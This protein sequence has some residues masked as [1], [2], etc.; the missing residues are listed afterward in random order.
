MSF[1]NASETALLNLLFN[2]SAWANVGDASG[3]QPSATAGSYFI[4]LHSSDPGEAGNQ[5]TNEISYTGYARVAVARSG[6]GWTVSGNSVQNA[7]LVQFGQCTSGTAT[8]THFA[9]GTA[10]SS[11][12]SVLMKGALSASLSI[13]NGIQP[14]FA[15]GALVASI[16]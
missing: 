9:I 3:L 11:T 6:S 7:A 14:Q 15:A 8:A 4:S 2:N 13:S 5:T 12:G 10:S 16:D 1:S